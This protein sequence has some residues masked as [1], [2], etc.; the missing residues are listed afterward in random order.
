MDEDGKEARSLVQEKRLIEEKLRLAGG[1]DFSFLLK[2]CSDLSDI[3]DE[4]EDVSSQMHEKE[5][6]A[7]EAKIKFS[8]KIRRKAKDMLNFEQQLVSEY[9]NK[10]ITLEHG[11]RMVSI[12]KLLRSKSVDKARREAKEFY[13]F[14]EMGSRLEIINDL[15]LKKRA[16]AERSLR[17]VEALLS[18]LEWLAKEPA[19]DEEKVKRHDEKVQIGVQLSKI[20]QGHVQSLKSMPMPGLLGK[21]R[22]DELGKIG[23]PEISGN[24]AEALAAFLEKSGLET[25]S[26]EQLHDMA[27]QSEQLLRHLGLDL[28][29]FR[30]EVAARRAFLFGIMSYSADSRA[31]DLAYLAKHDE[32]ARRLAERLSELEKTGEQDKR[33]WERTE[34]IRQMKEEL[35]GADKATF[36]KSLQELRALLDVL[37][38]KAAPEKAEESKEENGLIGSILKLFGKK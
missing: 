37:D 29:L 12:I 32:A 26:A 9:E 30:Q 14:L 27:R 36:E 17:G 10:H 38:G 23:F 5:H 18:D 16:Q 1:D 13:G 24:E 11:K 19:A 34:K 2:D 7:F 31:P 4:I 15:L 8:R 3:I 20:W 22:E 33:E 21:M 28:P 35:A 25:R 6:A